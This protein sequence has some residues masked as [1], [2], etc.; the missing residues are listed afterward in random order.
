MIFES[1]SKLRFTCSFAVVFFG[2]KAVGVGRQ[3]GEKEQKVNICNLTSG[4]IRTSRWL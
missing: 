1:V 2:D 4:I 3:K